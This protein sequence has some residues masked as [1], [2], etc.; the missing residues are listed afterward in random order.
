MADTVHQEHR[1]EKQNVSDRDEHN[2]G[3]LGKVVKKAHRISGKTFVVIP[4]GIVY[5]LGINEDTW[6]E[7]EVIDNGVFLRMCK[8]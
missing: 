7:E 3:N 2:I 5:K 8:L 6:F 4:D 1:Q